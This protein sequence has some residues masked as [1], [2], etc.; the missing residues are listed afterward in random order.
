MSVIR[1]FKKFS[2]ILSSH[3]KL[4]VVE[5]G[6]LMVI[7]GLLETCSVAFM[8]PFINTVM[9]SEETMRKWYVRWI[10][11]MLG[12]NSSRTFFVATAMVLALLYILKNLFL[13]WEY[14]IQ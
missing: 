8:L 13:I 1:V 5:L 4:R 10:C 3:Q 11:N 14:N 9:K 6:V 7:G 12:L 2:Y